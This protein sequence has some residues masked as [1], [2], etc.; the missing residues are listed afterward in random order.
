[1]DY[2]YDGSFEGL[3]TC[4]YYNYKVERATGIYDIKSYQCSILNQY[5]E[6][7]T[8]SKF[9][10]IVYN[11]INNKI[12]REALVVIYYAYLSCMNDRENYILKFIEFAFKKGKIVLDMYTHDNIY[13]VINMQKKVSRERRFFIGTLRFSEIEGILY[14]KYSPD[15]NLTAIITEHFADRYKNEKFIIHDTKRK[16]ASVYA[17]NNWQIVDATHIKIDEISDYELNILKLWKHYFTAH[18]IE[19]RTNI[20]LQFSKIPARYRK[21]IVEFKILS[22]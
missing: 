16:I 9:S 15:N 18:A 22:N 11:A 2:L 1:M 20:S 6:I 8:N 5:K 19:N 14:A 4:V 17:N 10:D 12:S 7:K 21:N 3:L 13:P